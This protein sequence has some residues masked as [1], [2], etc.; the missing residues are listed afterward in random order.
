MVRHPF[1]IAGIVGVALLLYDA[2]NHPWSP[3]SLF[4]P[5][6]LFGY[7]LANGGLVLLVLLF[8]RLSTLLVLAKEFYQAARW[9]KYLGPRELRPAWFD[10]FNPD[11]P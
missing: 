10:D 9:R 8:F 6:H 4:S 11:A 3:H 7:S 5:E 1:I 2:V